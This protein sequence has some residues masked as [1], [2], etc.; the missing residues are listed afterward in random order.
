MLS[1]VYS[2]SL[3]PRW[4]ALLQRI[5]LTLTFY[6][7]TDIHLWVKILIF[8][9]GNGWVGELPD[10]SMYNHPK[11]EY[12]PGVKCKS[13]R[14]EQFSLLQS[15]LNPTHHGGGTKRPPLIS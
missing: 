12:P 14:K 11:V 4:S 3:I 15:S 5:Y 8:L 10:F 9:S 1:A 7:L 6:L 2:Q 13:E